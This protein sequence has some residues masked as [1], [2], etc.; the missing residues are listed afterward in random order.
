MGDPRP[1][2]PEMT[3]ARQAEH[4]RRTGNGPTVTDEAA[5]LEGEFGE[6]DSE[7]A[8]GAPHTNGGDAA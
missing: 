7:G 2:D 1:E 3:P 6:P 8:Y 5:L 4:L